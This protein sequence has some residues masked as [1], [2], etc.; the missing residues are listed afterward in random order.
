M[1]ASLSQDFHLYATGGAT[2]QRLK[3]SLLWRAHDT[4]GG[5][6]TLAMFIG[7]VSVLTKFISHDTQDFDRLTDESIELNAPQDVVEVKILL[8]CAPGDSVAVDIYAPEVV[9]APAEP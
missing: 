6:C 1:S 9:I 3:G 5:D 8:T 2:T 7:G 4:N